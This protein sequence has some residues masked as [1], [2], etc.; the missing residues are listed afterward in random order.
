MRLSEE[1]QQ[2]LYN[3]IAEPIIDLRVDL[4]T[5]KLGGGEFDRALS[6]LVQEIWRRQEGVLKLGGL[7]ANADPE[8]GQA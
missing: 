3:S 5:G 2:A 1:R 7:Y 4:R 8:E 6:L